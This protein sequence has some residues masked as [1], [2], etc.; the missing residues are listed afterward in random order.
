MQYAAILE[1]LSVALPA[2][3]A[4]SGKLIKGNEK[5][6]IAISVF[7]LL[8]RLANK[9]ATEKSLSDLQS[10]DGGGYLNANALA[11]LYKQAFNPSGVEL[12][13]SVDGTDEEAVF[14]LAAKT[15]NYKSV[16]ESYTKQYT[17]NFTNDLKAEL[18]GDDYN[19]YLTIINS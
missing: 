4:F 3:L 2:F 18:S 8:K 7:L 6:I 11:T 19:K 14:E 13:M 16:Y 5:Y 12:L 1:I 10:G 15:S 9:A 17:R